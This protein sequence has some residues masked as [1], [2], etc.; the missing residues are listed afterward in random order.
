MQNAFGNCFSF[1]FSIRLVRHPRKA[2]EDLPSSKRVRWLDV[3]LLLSAGILVLA[4]P[5]MVVQ[6]IMAF[7][8]AAARFAL[9][10]D[11]PRIDT[12]HRAL[13]KVLVPTLTVV[14]GVLG[15]FALVRIHRKKRVRSVSRR[16][17]LV[18]LVGMTLLDVTYL[19]DLGYAFEAHYLIRAVTTPWLYLLSGALIAG[20]AYHLAVLEDTLSPLT[21]RRPDDESVASW[22]RR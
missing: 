2:Q 21:P 1:L 11:D 16:P 19:V 12:S 3:L 13:A 18:L 22:T 8:E 6:E 9:L 20:A 5:V 4:G 15:T 7:D 17:G 10:G 14:I